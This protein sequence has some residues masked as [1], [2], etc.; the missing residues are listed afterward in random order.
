MLALPP[1][2]ISG[3]Y[4]DN[5]SENRFLLFLELLTLVRAWWE[6]C[7]KKSGQAVV[8]LTGRGVLKPAPFFDLFRNKANLVERTIN[9]GSYI[10]KMRVNSFQVAKIQS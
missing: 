5:K 2:L 10:P 6:L 1:V 7:S 8:S 4:A 3:D 9:T